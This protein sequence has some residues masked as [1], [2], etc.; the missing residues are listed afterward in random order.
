MLRKNKLFDWNQRSDGL[1]LWVQETTDQ[2]FLWPTNLAI[3]LKIK[4]SWPYK[5]KHICATYLFWFHAPR[6]FLCPWIYHSLHLCGVCTYAYA[7]T[8]RVARGKIY[9]Q[10]I[11]FGNP[12]TPRA[13]SSFNE[14]V[15][16]T[17]AR[18]EL[19]NRC[20]DNIDSLPKSLASLERARRNAVS[21]FVALTSSW[22]LSHSNSE[23]SAEK[24]KNIRIYKLEK[25]NH[26][27]TKSNMK[28]S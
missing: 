6:I 5:V 22:S 24:I 13:I 21:F 16:I 27:C 2:Q 11:T 17:G 19:K 26:I 18:R 25:T 4:V 7:H 15:D 20:N 3:C 12:P 1:G 14:P 28:I 23:T 10:I 8:E 9:F